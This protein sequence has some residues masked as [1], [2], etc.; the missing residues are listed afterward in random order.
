MTGGFGC[1]GC[2]LGGTGLG[3][4]GL[5][6]GLGVGGR[7]SGCGGGCPGGT[8]SGGTFTRCRAGEVNALAREVGWIITLRSYPDWL[9]SNRQAGR[10]QH[11]KQKHGGPVHKVNSAE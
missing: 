5:G 4:A 11:A 10:Q 1:G 8:G 9:R 3:G 2:G 6:S 7:G